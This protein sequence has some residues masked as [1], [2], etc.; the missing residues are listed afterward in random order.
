MGCGGCEA[1]TPEKV[2]AKSN[3]TTQ[4]TPFT[5]SGTG[6][7]SYALVAI[8]TINLSR[9]DGATLLCDYTTVDVVPTNGSCNADCSQATTCSF[10]VVCKF[11]FTGSAPAGAQGQNDPTFGPDVEFTPPAGYD[12]GGGSIDI[13]HVTEVVGF[14]PGDPDDPA[15]TGTYLYDVTYDVTGTVAPGCGSSVSITVNFANL[16]TTTAGW[17][18]TNTAAVEPDSMTFTCEACKASKRVKELT[19]ASGKNAVADI[20]SRE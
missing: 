3:G 1:K 11:K 5:A 15:D 2:T 20:E 19:Q 10:S 17:T 18:R 4:T 8:G 9:A 7:G 13:E 14:L 6:A 12:V 16:A